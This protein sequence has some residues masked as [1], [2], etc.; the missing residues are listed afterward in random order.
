[1]ESPRLMIKNVNYNLSAHGSNPGT[2]FNLPPNTRILLPSLPKAMLATAKA[3]CTFAK[4]NLTHIDPTCSNIHKLIQ[5]LLA[6]SGNHQYKV[7]DSKLGIKRCPNINY[8]AENEKTFVTGIAKCPVTI[9][10]TYLNDHISGAGA[11]IH[12]DRPPEYRQQG[13]TIIINDPEKKIDDFLESFGRLGFATINGLF[14]SRHGL[15]HNI[16]ANLLF[17][18]TKKL[19]QDRLPDYLTFYDK[20]NYTTFDHIIYKITGS[21]IASGV[22]IN[23]EEIV[24]YYRAEVDRTDGQET[25]MTIITFACNHF[26]SGVDVAQYKALDEGITYDEFFDKINY[27]L[28]V[29]ERSVSAETLRAIEQHKVNE[30]LL[31]LIPLVKI[32]E[33]NIKDFLHRL[34]TEP[35]TMLFEQRQKNMILNSKIRKELTK[36]LKL[37]DTNTIWDNLG[38]LQ[39]IDNQEVKEAINKYIEGLSMPEFAG[40]NESA[41]LLGGYIQ[42]NYYLK[43]Q[44]YKNKYLNLHKHSN[45]IYN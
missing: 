12:S 30:R 27:Q 31:S 41:S 22:S 5:E 24:R 3:E 29:V 23:L 34:D 10:Q 2:F 38:L 32:V 4:M 8:S 37:S 40:S 15:K 25:I 36:T 13:E 19:H 16:I 35:S 44:K 9:K 43:Y 6:S 33:Q 20:E 17:P 7:Y 21:P 39:Y 11:G 45:K 42:N 28:A 26:E 18:Y 14:A 1:M